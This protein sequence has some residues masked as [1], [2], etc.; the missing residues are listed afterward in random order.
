M[1]AIDLLIISGRLSVMSSGMLP[2][3]MLLALIVGRPTPC[4]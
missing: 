4:S 2:S 3:G 1:Q